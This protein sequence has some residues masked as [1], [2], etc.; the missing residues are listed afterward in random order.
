MNKYLLVAILLLSA[1]IAFLV[2]SAFYGEGEVGL[3]LFIPFFYGDDVWAVL[4]II[5]IVFAML[6]GFIGVASRTLYFPMR[7]DESE[8]QIEF[9]ERKVEKKIG[10]VVLIGP[11]PIAFGSDIKMVI[12]AIILAIILIV[13]VFLLLI[14]SYFP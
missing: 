1:G 5:C 12:I 11:V 7:S 9:A 14:F 8:K 13:I 3:I 4:G 10:G 2:I 6:L